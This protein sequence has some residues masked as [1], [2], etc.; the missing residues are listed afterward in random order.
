MPHAACLRR[1]HLRGG[2]T[3]PLHYRYIIVTGAPIFEVAARRASA[4]G[5]LLYGSELPEIAPEQILH[6]GDDLHNDFLAARA[7]GQRALLYDPK[8][9]AKHAELTPEDVVRPRANLPP[10]ISY[11]SLSRVPRPSP[12]LSPESLPAK[13]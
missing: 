3:L 9:E 10:P 12:N 6:V 1:A 7:C 4:A 5:R 8:G 2:V 13:L 11:I